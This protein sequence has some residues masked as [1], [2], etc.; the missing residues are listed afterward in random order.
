[1]DLRL[2]ALA[3]VPAVLLL[4]L[5]PDAILVAAGEAKGCVL[6][7]SIH[8]EIS[9]SP[10][11]L[12]LLLL[13]VLLLVLVPAAAAAAPA[14]ETS[15]AVVDTFINSCSASSPLMKETRFVI[16]FCFFKCEAQN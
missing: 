14:L 12:L 15:S 6:V 2:V 3:V 10:S 9:E 7:L 16:C 11:A 5:L 4:L 13:V 1:M 8:S